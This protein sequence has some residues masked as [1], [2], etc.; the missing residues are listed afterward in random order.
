M[1]LT[2]GSI[3]R[4]G[5]V[6]SCSIPKVLPSARS[7][8]R[9]GVYKQDDEVARV[10]F[11]CI[12]KVFESGISVSRRDYAKRLR[13]NGFLEERSKGPATIAFTAA[14]KTAFYIYPHAHQR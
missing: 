2:L 3:R 10:A 1:S 6:I 14:L 5:P 7:D 4:T 9:L 12:A 13:T 8:S 11:Q